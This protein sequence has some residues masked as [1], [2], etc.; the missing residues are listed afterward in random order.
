MSCFG[1][2]DTSQHGKVDV[3]ELISHPTVKSR[4]MAPCILNTLAPDT[5]WWKSLW[6]LFGC[7]SEYDDIYTEDTVT[8][9]IRCTANFGG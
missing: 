2:S 9:T 8:L 1:Y 4:D 3:P 7:L 5:A 6:Y